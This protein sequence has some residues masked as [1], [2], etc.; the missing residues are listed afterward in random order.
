MRKQNVGQNLNGYKNTVEDLCKR[1]P[2]QGIL[3]GV[4]LAKTRIDFFKKWVII[5]KAHW[6]KIKIWLSVKKFFLTS[7]LILVTRCKHFFNSMES[8]WT[9]E[10]LYLT[11]VY[12]ALCCLYQ[13]FDGL[14]KLD[15]LSIKKG[16]FNSQP[17]SQVC[18]PL[19][20]I[21]TLVK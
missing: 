1:R 17:D 19:P 7:D 11:Q 4:K 20:S 12:C 8:A 10:I 13:V 18:L 5:S 2:G 6:Y 14:R 16:K 9:Q 3:C 15:L 21:V